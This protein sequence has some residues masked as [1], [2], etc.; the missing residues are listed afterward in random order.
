MKYADC[1]SR[2]LIAQIPL[3]DPPFHMTGAC[4]ASET[5]KLSSKMS[6]KNSVEIEI[7]WDWPPESVCTSQA[8][9]K[10][11]PN[12]TCKTRDDMRKCFCNE[13]FKWD[14][15]SLNCTQGEDWGCFSPSIFLILLSGYVRS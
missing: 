7:S 11:R 12:W 3:P 4:N 1:S 6:L 10:D 14:G 2:S 5:D 9:R 8:D 13:N 15:S